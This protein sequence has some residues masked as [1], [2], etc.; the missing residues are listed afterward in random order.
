MCR[1]RS[2]SGFTLI[3]LLVVIA[4]IAVL[5]GLLIPAVQVVREAA[6]RAS[7]ANN[8]KQ[9]GLAM[10]L[11]H[12][13]HN[14]FPPGIGPFPPQPQQPFGNVFFHL[15]PYIEQGNLYHT[16]YR[17]DD[18]EVYSKGIKLF[19]CP[20]DPSVGPDG[21]VEDNSDQTW[22]A[23]SYAANAQV[24]CNVTNAGDLVDVEGRASL[25]YSFQDGASN[26]ILFAEKYAR[27]TNG[28]YPE[29]GSLWAYSQTRATRPPLHPGFAISWNFGS[30]G[31]PSKFQ[32]QP[33]PF[34]GNCDP[35][36]ASTGHR[37]GIQVCMADGHVRLIAPSVR[38]DTWWAL[39][40]PSA[41]DQLGSDW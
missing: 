3:E 5:I 7:C 17:W 23:S 18:P 38:G 4:I 14:R 29:G 11:Y 40:T 28:A 32:Q 30:I 31:P 34:L 35:T 13:S 16:S 6:N 10:H 33:S 12:D 15:L 41:G 36:R 19:C 2:N 1:R 22:G 21:V 20:S 24:V 25:N 39:C 26:T 37:G 27:C 8:L 9:L